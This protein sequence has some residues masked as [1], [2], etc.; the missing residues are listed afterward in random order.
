[1]TP[2]DGAV[3]R[4]GLVAKPDDP[5]RTRIAA[6]V[7]DHLRQATDVK[8]F[9]PPDL[10]KQFPEGRV[11]SLTPERWAV[12]AVVTV[13]GDGT[14]LW[15]LQHANAPVLGINFG[16]LGF[17]TEIEPIEL[18]DGLDRLLKREYRLEHRMRVASR[19]SGRALPDALNEVVVK[20]PRPAKILRFQV[21][22][23]GEELMSVKADGIIVSTPTGSTSYGM[24]AGGPIVDPRLEAIVIVP[25]AA[26][27]LASRPIVLPPDVEVSIR[28]KEREK[29]AVVVVDGQYETEMTKDDT[30]SVTRSAHAAQF[31]RYRGGF[32]GRLRERLGLM[33]ETPMG[34]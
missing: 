18:V 24:S 6:F 21:F 27:R 33:G 9:A 15:T 22:Q 10:A 29:D 4:I 28:L 3:K 32:Y 17:L 25:L 1:M 31:I 2:P 11:H 5:Q 34:R 30:L 26:F 20:T 23:N 16:E 19:L 14:I 12:D 13:G 7:V 8:I